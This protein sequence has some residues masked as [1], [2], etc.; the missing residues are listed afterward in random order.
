MLA[1]G[2]SVLGGVAMV[3]SLIRP[4]VID[5]VGT[6]TLASILALLFL[7]VVAFVT[8]RI[9]RSTPVPTARHSDQSLGHL[10]AS[11]RS[12]IHRRRA[13]RAVERPP[14]TRG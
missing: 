7:P 14:V 12:P 9:E 3:N 8:M 1:G 13:A 10:R 2:G 6:L 11:R 5:S 4:G